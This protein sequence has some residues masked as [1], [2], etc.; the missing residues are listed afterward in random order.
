M[1]RTLPEVLPWLIALAASSVAALILMFDGALDA[2]LQLAAPRGHFYIVTVVALISVVVGAAGVIAAHR[3][4]NLRVLFLALGFLS[5]AGIFAVHGLATPGFIL[6][7]RAFGV[8]GF[9]ARLAVLVSSMFLGLSVVPWPAELEARFIRRRLILT[10]GWVAVLFGYAAVAITDPESL[11]PDLTLSPGFQ[12]TAALVTIGLSGF[13]ALRYFQGYRRTAR[14]L[15]GGVALGAVLLIEAQAGM[16]FGAVW[17]GTFWL[18]HVQLL[19]GFSAIAWGLLTEYSRGDSWLDAIGRLGEADLVAQVQSGYS[20]SIGGL[21]AALEA[22]DGYTLGHG[23]RVGALAVLIGKEL[24]F[25]D[26]RLRAVAQGA[27]L[28]DVGKIGV[29]DAILHK[30]GPLDDAEFEVIKE[31][32]ARGH[33]ILGASFGTAV[34]QG[35]VRHHHERWDGTGYPDGLAGEEIPVEAR[36]VAVADVYDALRSARSYRVAWDRGRAVAQVTA[37]IGTHFDALC[38]DAFLRVVDEWEAAFADDQA[39]YEERRAAA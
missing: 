29:P 35:I 36:V 9:S 5:M 2:R 33:A 15:F 34:E 1:R 10:V 25:S 38:V 11:P 13:A 31:H 14:P 21:A 30:A 4:A 3:T 6:D 22:R 19:L 7:Q 37:D 12:T 17:G 23:R 26:P 32:P 27:L 8:T 24:G 20:E 39:R 16:Y 18:Y 28:H